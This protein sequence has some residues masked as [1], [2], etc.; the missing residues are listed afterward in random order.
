MGQ[1]RN[2][3]DTAIVVG[4]IFER[5]LQAPR[6]RIEIRSNLQQQLVMIGRRH[7]VRKTAM[8]GPR[9]RCELGRNYRGMCSWSGHES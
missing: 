6:E 2:V 1:R 7:A 4:E 8:A 5:M 9:F 3:D